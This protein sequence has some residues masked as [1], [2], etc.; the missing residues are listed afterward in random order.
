VPYQRRLKLVAQANKS[1]VK[2]RLSGED[3][4]L[5]YDVAKEMEEVLRS[6]STGRGGGILVSVY[7]SIRVRNAQS[8]GG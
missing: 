2:P 7:R 3:I 5:R 1:G 6:L 8:V 4:S